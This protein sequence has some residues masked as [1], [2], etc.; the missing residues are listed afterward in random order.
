MNQVM[1]GPDRG[2]KKGGA[3]PLSP[4][5]DGHYVSL[6]NHTAQ[7]GRKR[8]PLRLYFFNVVQK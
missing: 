8:I 6:K 7:T 5:A 1:K 2:R 4:H 3:S